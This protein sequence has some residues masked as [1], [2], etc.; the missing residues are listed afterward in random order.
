MVQGISY[1]D[2]LWNCEIVAVNLLEECSVLESY[3]SFQRRSILTSILNFFEWW[4]SGRAPHIWIHPGLFWHHLEGHNPS[5]LSSAFWPNC[6]IKRIDY[7]LIPFSL[8][9]LTFVLWNWMTRGSGRNP[10]LPNGN[11]H[12]HLSL[13]AFMWEDYWSGF[14]YCGFYSK[15]LHVISFHR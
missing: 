5:K 8:L 4:S 13:I 14:Y 11:A 2:S 3:Q 9:P 7:D 15:G 1:S 12:H 10:L 6:D